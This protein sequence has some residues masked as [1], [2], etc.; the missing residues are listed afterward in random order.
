VI[1]A[2]D[3]NVLLDLVAHDAPH[4]VDSLSR[5]E[6]SSEAGSLV[7]AEVVYAELCPAFGAREAVERFLG[8]TGIGLRRSGEEALALAGA[9]LQQYRR[10]RPAGVVCSGCG[11]P[12]PIRCTNC[13]E[14]VATRQH[15]L[16]DFLIGAHALM[17]ADRLLTRDRGFYATYFPDLRLM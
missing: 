15:I 17:H 14:S 6:E 3:T 5:L 8:S 7:I 2:V 1:T 9:A 11:T 13:G 10:R 16:A 4:R 12:Q